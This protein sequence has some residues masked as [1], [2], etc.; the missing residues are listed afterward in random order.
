[1][2]KG[3]FAGRG[4]IIVLA[5][6]SSFI[7]A[8]RLTSGHVAPGVFE[9]AEALPARPSQVYKADPETGGSSQ[10]ES[11]VS[12]DS[13]STASERIATETPQAD[14]FVPRSWLPPPPPPP[15]MSAVAPALPPTP[16]APAMPFNFIG[17]IDNGA[18][19]PKAFLTHSES[20]HIVAK[21]DLVEKVYRVESITPTKVVLTYLPMMQEQSINLTGPAR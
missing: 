17:Q 2:K 20:L 3:F 14:P 1:M 21:G 11:A 12:L 4:L 13:A 18:D 16:T 9:V 8:V 6:L 7:G 10:A 15:S 5:G 19:L